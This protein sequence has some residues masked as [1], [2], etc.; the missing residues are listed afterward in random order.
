MSTGVTAVLR[1]RDRL[2]EEFRQL[3]NCTLDVNDIGRL[4]TTLQTNL[5][6]VGRDA[7]FE[8]LR[9]YAGRELFQSDWDKLAWLIAGNLPRLEAGSAITE[10]QIQSAEEWVPVQVTRVFPDKDQYQNI[11]YRLWLTVLSGSPAGCAFQTTRKRQFLSAMSRKMGFTRRHGKLPYL[12]G[13]QYMSLRFSAKLRPSRSVQELSFDAVDV[14]AGLVTWNKTILRQRCRVIPCPQ[15][16]THQC[17]RCVLGSDRCI[18]ATH[19]LTYQQQAC[20]ACGDEQAWFDPE[21]TTHQCV[22]CEK[23]QAW[24]TTNGNTRTA[25]T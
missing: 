21:M 1:R 23:R 19:R 17:H 15:G 18:G 7:L 24:N 8:T 10:W 5:P 20:P 9:Q 3:W 2:R 14:P 25:C 4:I 13:Y 16:F 12:S 11:G 6:N 22:E